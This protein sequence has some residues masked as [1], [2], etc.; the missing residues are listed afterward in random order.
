MKQR[1]DNKNH[2]NTEKGKSLQKHVQIVTETQKIIL[3]FGCFSI[4]KKE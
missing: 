2:S 4:L 3:R 1:R